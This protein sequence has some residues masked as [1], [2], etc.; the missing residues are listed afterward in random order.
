[1]VEQLL[2]WRF[3]RYL[4]VALLLVLLV[5]ERRL[6]FLKRRFHLLCLNDDDLGLLWIHVWKHLCPLELLLRRTYLQCELEG[7]FHKIL[8]DSRSILRIS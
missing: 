7:R 5:L 4:H 3:R 2:P 6:L 1:M 8:I